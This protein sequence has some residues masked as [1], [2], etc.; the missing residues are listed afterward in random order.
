MRGIKYLLLFCI[1]SVSVNLFGQEIETLIFSDIFN[2]KVPG[3]ERISIPILSKE[4]RLSNKA[5]TIL[6]SYSDVPIEV[7]KC[8]EFA[9]IIWES[10]IENSQP[11]KIKFEYADIDEDIRTEVVYN[12]LGGV[13]YPYSLCVYNGTVPSHNSNSYDGTIY[14]NKNKPWDYSV[15]EKISANE[16]NLTYGLVR[17]IGRI[18]GF[19][20]TIKINNNGNYYFGSKRAFSYFDGLITTS[21]NKFL[22]NIPLM[23]GGKKILN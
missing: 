5:T 3:K 15:G 20:S 22:T 16:N 12:S 14:I 9:V 18:L 11:L 6:R 7:Q 13:L 1:M 2:D 10:N 23:G 17:A 21:D 8:I 4:Q 19:G